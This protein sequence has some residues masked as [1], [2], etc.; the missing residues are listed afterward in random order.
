MLAQEIQN[1][2]NS[3][4]VLTL[5]L[6]I[7]AASG[8]VIREI[9]SFLSKQKGGE[10]HTTA[11]LARRLDGLEARINTVAGNSQESRDILITVKTIVDSWGV[12]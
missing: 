12:Q 9:F 10:Q 3:S 2:S 6:A 1:V 11:E 7:L 8:V 4:D 5:S